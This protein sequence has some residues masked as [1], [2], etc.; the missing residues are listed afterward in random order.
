MVTDINTSQLF[1]LTQ[2]TVQINV[3]IWS[4]ITIGSNY[5]N[6]QSENLYLT[7]FLTDA[8]N[9]MTATDITIHI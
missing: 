5:R 8:T 4:Q 7:Y 3:S 6:R 1:I 9:V 2:T